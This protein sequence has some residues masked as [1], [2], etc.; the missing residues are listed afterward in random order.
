MIHRFK[1]KQG[2]V[3]VRAEL[4]GPTGK[5][6]LRLALDTGATNT[7][8]NVGMLVAIGCDP[9]TSRER[10]EVTTGSGVEFAPRVG[11]KRLFVLG[12]ERRSF[13]VLAHTLPPSAGVDG[14]LGLDFFRDRKLGIDFRKGQ[15]T[16]A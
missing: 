9:A 10:V 13:R 3:V 15:I 2:L 5:A 11:L 14:L 16:V 4:T 8:I 6:S 7:L 1:A 12:S